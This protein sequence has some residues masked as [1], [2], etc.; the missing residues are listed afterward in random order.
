[1]LQLLSD[2]TGTLELA[3]G[4]S[5]RVLVIGKCFSQPNELRLG[6]R[7]LSV[8]DGRYS[9]GLVFGGILRNGEHREQAYYENQY[10][11]HFSPLK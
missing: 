4:G 5:E 1:V 3:L 11:F 10:L 9:F 2:G 8:Q 7:E 6:I